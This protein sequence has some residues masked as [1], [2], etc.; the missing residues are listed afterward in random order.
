M[1]IDRHCSEQPGRGMGAQHPMLIKSFFTV[2]PD[3]ALLPHARANTCSDCVR[4][5]MGAPYVSVTR[6]FKEGL[7]PLGSS[8]YRF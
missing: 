3:C 1:N 5:P 6:N 7:I 2:R 4:Q 8:F